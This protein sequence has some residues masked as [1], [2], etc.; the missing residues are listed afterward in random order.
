MSIVEPPAPPAP[1]VV[2]VE[3]PVPVP[4]PELELEED[5]EPW[6]EDELPEL[7]DGPP[8]ESLTV[9]EHAVAN[10]SVQPTATS[11]GKRRSCHNDFFIFS[12]ETTEGDGPKGTRHAAESSRQL[13]RYRPVQGSHAVV[14]FGNTDEAPW[15][16][17]R[18][19][20]KLLRE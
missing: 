1:V 19:L 4:D 11:L 8:D 12:S 9:P 3:V 7:A 14:S 15:E 6:A 2:P 10:A 5:V 13:V 17:W 20:R 16:K 18:M